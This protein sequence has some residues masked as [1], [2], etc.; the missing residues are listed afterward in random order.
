MRLFN[1]KARIGLSWSSAMLLSSA[2][3]A[4]DRPLDLR[5]FVQGHTAVRAVR[6]DCPPQTECD[7][8]SGELRAEIK[9]DKSSPGG[10][11]AFVGRADVAEDLLFRNTVGDVRELYGNITFRKASIRIG[12]Q[13]ITWGVG[14][15]LFINDTFPKNFNAFFTGQPIE[16]LKDGSDAV[17]IDL[18]PGLW[19]VE[20]IT[21]HFRPE[22]T[23]EARR[24]VFPA[25]FIPLAGQPTV[26]RPDGYGNDLET[27]AK[28]ART[29]GRWETVAYASKT[30]YHSPDLLP[31]ASDFTLLYPRLNTYGFSL[32]GPLAK[33]LLNIEAGYFDSA[34]NTDGK[35]PFLEQSQ[36]RILLG[37]SRQLW[38]DS[39]FGIQFYGEDTR[40]YGVYKAALPPGAPL[41]P[42][43]RQLVT[44]RFTQQMRNQTLTFNFFAFW[45]LSE[46]DRYIIPSVRYAF[47]DAI[48][49]EIGA[50]IFAGNPTGQFGSLGDNK[51]TYVTIRYS[52]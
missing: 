3:A 50:N 19:S 28:L 37:H 9:V 33:G 8:M 45:G 29:F 22:T 31:Q 32:T 20:V 1:R 39:N 30:H 52:F 48:W 35:N 51:N 38:K 14:D 49:G 44:T 46:H 26:L 24:F 47:T 12:R 7:V 17:K 2:I 25:S 18:Y 21:A 36:V 13:I 10:L 15:L 40:N 27:S 5:G 4:Q 11:L 34:Q 41:R 23:P 42:R 6:P 16:Y 43:F